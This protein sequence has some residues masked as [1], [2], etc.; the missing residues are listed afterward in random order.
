[1]STC[2]DSTAEQDLPS[3]IPFP[4][5]YKSVPGEFALSPEMEV[6]ASRGLQREAEFLCRTISSSTG[7]DLK[8]SVVEN[9]AASSKKRRI[10]FLQQEGT[11]SS[12]ESYRLEV[13]PE[14]VRIVAAEPRGAF[15]AV[16]TL[17]QMFPPAI[18]TDGP[19][20][21]FLPSIRCCKVEDRPRFRWRGLMLDSVRYFQPVDY[22][23]RWID[24]LSQHKFNT[25]HWHLTD[26][27][28][29][30]VEI[31]KYPRLTEIGAWRNG[32]MKG[33]L[34]ANGPC[35]GRRY[36]GFY[37][38]DEIREIVAYAAERHVT[39]VPEIEM[40][41]H[42][43]AAVASYPELGVDNPRCEVSTKWGIHETLFNPEEA[44]LAFLKDV[45]TEVMEL[46]PGK[47]IHIGGDEAVKTQWEQSP[48]V[49][50]RM[51]ELNIPDTHALQS[52]FIKQMAEFLS[53]NGR[54]LVGW[55]EIL[56]GG[57]AP[58]AIVMSWRGVEGGIEAARQGHHAVMSPR[59]YTYFDY[60]QCPEEEC[61]PLTIGD[62]VS[63][64]DVYTYEPIAR[65]LRPEE[66]S[67]VL[68]VQGQLWTEYIPNTSR[69]EYMAFPR[70]CA[71]AEV[72]WGKRPKASFEDF[73]T[74]LPLHL[75]RLDCQDVRY[76]PRIS[77][78]KSA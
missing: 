19:R 64:E 2:P 78:K 5:H 10:V 52:W 33:H 48:S 32:T 60:Y 8:A 49:R 77:R 41:G 74:R 23:K 71:L 9:S 34:Y 50:K 63:L 21:D 35:D 66:A 68:G 14:E 73:L 75:R 72:A 4:V 20:K 3:L 18:Y 22:I 26:D 11:D 51:Q 28:G 12:P 58:G 43:Q 56:E 7:L 24:L 76:C 13:S 47:Y 27:Q 55:D 6:L 30:R 1:M 69:L 44:T 53:Q 15:Y 57:L 37:S 59:F 65:E 31:K 61:E 40:P 46:F 29:W 54:E 16:Q 42:A 70:A 36:G 62:Y 45:L 39:I 67:K 38:Q 17:L 25:F